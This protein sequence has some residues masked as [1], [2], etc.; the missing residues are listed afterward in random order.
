MHVT[1]QI[2]S[3]LETEGKERENY[4]DMRRRKETFHIGIWFAFPSDSQET[5]GTTDTAQIAD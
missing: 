3:E 4:R 1:W 2:P 5:L